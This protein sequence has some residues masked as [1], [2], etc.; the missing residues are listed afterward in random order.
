[1]MQLPSLLLP[2]FR[3][4]SHPI[5]RRYTTTTTESLLLPVLESP[6]FRNVPLQHFSAVSSSSTQAQQPPALCLRS[7]MMMSTSTDDTA[8]DSSSS[9]I[10]SQQRIKRF[11][12]IV[13]VVEV[14][15]TNPTTTTNDLMQH[16]RPPPSQLVVSSET[17]TTS[18]S[19]GDNNTAST[20]TSSTKK[21]YTV[22]LD[23]KQLK[24]PSGQVVV[25]P[26]ITLA[27]LIAIEWNNVTSHIIPN[28]MP[29]MTYVCT[30]LD[31]VRKEKAHY[32]QLCFQYVMTDTLGYPA[33]PT[34]EPI[35]Y[36]QQQK[37]WLPIKH[38]IH[39]FFVP[40]NPSTNAPGNPATTT[41]TT[42][43]P[44]TLPVVLL[45]VV[46]SPR[47]VSSHSD[48]PHKKSNALLSSLS[49]PNHHTTLVQ[50]IQYDPALLLA[51]Q[52][53]ISN[54]DVWHLLALYIGCKECKSFWLS[55]ALVTSSTNSPSPRP[56][57]SRFTL[58]PAQIVT[59]A[60]LEE[61]CNIQDWGLV[62]GQHDYDRLNAAIQVRSV[63]LYL[64]ALLAPNTNHNNES[65]VSPPKD[66]NK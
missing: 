20:D 2:S 42:N 56:T 58:T 50:K 43:V 45:P 23:G 16:P 39:S 9:N 48:P 46:A 40:T 19:D 35:L 27:H 21:W 1:M 30:V 53:Y 14:V 25:V 57:V 28:Q 4:Q 3:R 51:I 66:L 10:Q 5:L 59:A 8:N 22:T 62:E 63:A 15:T 61:E 11:Y 41:T 37:A 38:W 55:C 12:K 47:T 44:L 7:R 17:E 36:Q 49:H 13:N 6:R 52:Q 34:S 32:E 26:T 24:T 18:S 54:L 31:Q 64:H 29:I 60:R 65:K 33:N